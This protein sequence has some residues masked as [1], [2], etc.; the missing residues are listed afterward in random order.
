MTSPWKQ[1]HQKVSSTY[2]DLKLTIAQACVDSGLRTTDVLSAL[3]VCYV[4]LGMT[5]MRP[6]ADIEE[7][8]DALMDGVKNA[9][10]HA[11]KT[12]EERLNDK[13]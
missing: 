8:I 6:G 13:P 12:I 4:T 9:I 5:H 1:G 7:T 3:A 11:R 10:G 2:V